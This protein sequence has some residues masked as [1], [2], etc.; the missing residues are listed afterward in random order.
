MNIKSYIPNAFTMANLFCGMLGVF[1]AATGHLDYAAYA[2][3][4]G[5]F[6]DFFDGFFARMF[7]VEGELG[8]QLD[9]LADVVTSGVVPGMVMFQM[10]H[11]LEH[12]N[13]GERWVEAGLSWESLSLLPFLGFAITLASAFRL[14]KFN[15]DTRQTTSFI[16]LPTPA[17]ALLIL[18]LPLI[19][20][21]QDYAIAETLITNTWFLL[22]LTALSCYMLNAE[23]PLF[24]LKFKSWGLAE[25]KIRYGFLLL[26]IIL[27][28]WLTFAAIPL[29]IIAYVLI[30]IA[31]RNT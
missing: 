28:F 31:T 2:V 3:V 18:S 26:A 14:A 4:A 21:F 16:G 19:V 7:K 30:S 6:F 12:W 8:L 25:N 11:K 10:L 29:I 23:I 13:T 24:A 27:L 1:F 17:N 20:Q 15:I 22:A 5:V 9:S